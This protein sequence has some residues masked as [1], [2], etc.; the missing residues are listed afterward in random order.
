MPAQRVHAWLPSALC[1]LA[2]LWPSWSHSWSVNVT[3]GQRRL[4]LQVGVG[5]QYLD[6]RTRNTVSLTVP[7][8]ALGNQV[9]QRM[10]SN[11]TQANSSFNNAP[12]CETIQQ[13]VYVAA[14]YRAPASE[15]GTAQ[16]RVLTPP[17]LTAPSGLTMPIGEIG[18]ASG[19]R[20]GGMDIPT[21]YFA[22]GTQV[23]A[24]LP[25]NRWIEN[26]LT[27]SYRNSA[28]LGAGTY[29]ATAVFTLVAP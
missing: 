2:A 28:K 25:A 5:T 6:N 3:P 15:R 8:G 7:L 20:N 29:S 22:G 27:F 19:H 23:L 21:G 24:S 10:N 9:P 18:W 14:A 12:A 26:C 17:Q 4:F 16:L 13:Q 11:S 1:L